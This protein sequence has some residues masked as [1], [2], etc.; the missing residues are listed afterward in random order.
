MGR[1]ELAEERIREFEDKL[2]EIMQNKEQIEKRMMEKE[3]SFR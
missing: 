1:F 2:I 3:P